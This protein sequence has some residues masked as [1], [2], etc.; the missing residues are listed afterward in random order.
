MKT[1]VM[2]AGLLLTPLAHAQFT[3]NQSL[4][5][6]FKAVPV[7]AGPVT[8]DATRVARLAADGQLAV[9]GTGD[10]QAFDLQVEPDVVD[11][12]IRDN[13]LYVLL[14]TKIQEWDLTT[15]AMV[16]ET[17]T[18]EKAR[19]GMR[20]GALAM[21]FY[22]DQLVI[23][24]GRLGYAI[25]DTKSHAIVGTQTVLQDQAPLESALVDVKVQGDQAVFVVDSYTL[26]QG[27]LKMPFRGFL[28]IDLKTQKE[29]HRAKGVDIGAT[30]LEIN[31]DTIMV[32]FD[33]PIQSFRMTEVTGRGD[34]RLR[35]SVFKYEKTGH[36]IGQPVVV[37]DKLFTCFLESPK[38]GAAKK[39]VPMVL[40]LKAFKL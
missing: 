29:I 10:F 16:S 40:D 9:N 25:Y 8:A 7:C 24:E 35:R 26:V 3:Q 36:P 17:M 13:V 1:L 5:D 31:G 11:L 12:K 38:P 28:L 39:S 19:P 27:G 15:R 22:G 23:A 4:E 20:E 14:P 33:G 18:N 32:G 6:A 30:M 34:V 2:I 37:G 21:D